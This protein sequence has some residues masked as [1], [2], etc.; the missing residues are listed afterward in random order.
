MAW[1]YVQRTG[2]LF[3]DSTLVDTGY[4]GKGSGKNN[5]DEQCVADEGPI[6]RGWWGILPATDTGPTKLSLPL[7]PDG[8]TCGRSGFF[9]H[10]DS[11][12]NPGNASHGCIILKKSTRQQIDD[13]DDKRLQ[14]VSDSVLARR[15]LRPK[16]KSNRRKAARKK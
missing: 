6:P 9:I 2:S 12:T 8:E 10:G 1:K 15:K 4:A 16:K 5:P 14:V 7:S 13:S 3:Q 11:I